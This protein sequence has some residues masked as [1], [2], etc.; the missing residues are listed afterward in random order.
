VQNNTENWCNNCG[1]YNWVNVYDEG[2]NFVSGYSYQWNVAYDPVDSGNQCRA[3]TTYDTDGNDGDA[4]GGNWYN[5]VN[6]CAQFGWSSTSGTDYTEN[7]GS[8]SGTSP[9]T[10]FTVTSCTNPCGWYTLDTQVPVSYDV[11]SYQQTPYTPITLNTTTAPAASSISEDPNPMSLTID[12][13]QPVVG[14]VF[15][16]SHVVGSPAAFADRR[17]SLV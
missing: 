13:I 4:G 5:T 10:Y 17:R 9:F 16:A 15:V 11:L 6:G 3:Y 14:S 2:S 7:Y 8:T 1:S 12:Q